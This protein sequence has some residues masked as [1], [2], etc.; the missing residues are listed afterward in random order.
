M[1]NIQTRVTLDEHLKGIMDD[2][3]A[4]KWNTTAKS[5]PKKT[6]KSESMWDL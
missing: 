1:D 5:K 2:M 4:F 6:K 3:N